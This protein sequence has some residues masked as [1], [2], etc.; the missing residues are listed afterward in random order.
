MYQRAL[1]IR[2]QMLGA[3]HPDTATSLNNLANLYRK[4]E[5]YEL[6]EPLYQRAISIFER[7][8]GD[9]H[10]NTRAGRRNYVILLRAMGHEEEARRMEEEL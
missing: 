1:E 5:K 7:T 2:E 3:Q 6:A 10:P 8:F 4:Q 9:E